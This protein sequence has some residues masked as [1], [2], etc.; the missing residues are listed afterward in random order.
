MTHTSQLSGSR[1]V[2]LMMCQIQVK[3]PDDHTT[4]ARALLDSTSSALFIM[5]RT[6]QHLRPPHSHHAGKVSGI[7]GAMTQS[8]S[9][10]MVVFKVTSL[11]SKEK[12][13]CRNLA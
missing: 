3:S 5:K 11:K 2:L 7:R 12:T 10:G 9:Q 13:Q 1:Q 8:S 6:A 4:Q